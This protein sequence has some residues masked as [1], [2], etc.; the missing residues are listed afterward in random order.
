MLAKDLLKHQFSCEYRE[1]RASFANPKLTEC[2]FCFKSYDSIYDE[3]S[4]FMTDIENGVHFCDAAEKGW[5]TE[6]KDIG[7]RIDEKRIANS[8]EIRKY[9]E[10]FRCGICNNVLRKPKTCGNCKNNFCKHCI[11][12]SLMN[13]NLC[14][15][16]YTPEPDYS[17][18]PRNLM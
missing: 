8:E 15:N 17:N 10:I 4:P 5:C 9:L 16:C 14:P 12:Q 7:L 18:F 2:K 13:K 11:S 3:N 6:H 1:R